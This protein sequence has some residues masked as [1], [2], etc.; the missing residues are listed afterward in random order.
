MSETSAVPWHPMAAYLYV[1]WLDGPDLAWEYLRRH[2]N[3]RRDWR[4]RREGAAPC[5]GLRLL[6]DPG[7]DA[8]DALPAWLCSRTSLQLHP[9]A[10][11]PPGVPGFR[12]WNLPGRRQLVRDD[13]CLRLVARW[14]GASL[15]AVLAP[16]LA[17]GMPGV[18]ATP[19]GV[20]PCPR[21]G[22]LALGAEPN[23]APASAARVSARPSATALLEL[24][25]L[26]ALDATLAGASLREVARG[27][28]GAAAVGGSWHADSGLRSRV[29]RLVRRGRVLMQGGYRDLLTSRGPVQRGRCRACA[30]RP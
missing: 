27:L 17:D 15:R 24:H 16:G 19:T 8:R 14:P 6:E 7:L 30:K 1:L 3:Y 13:R 18:F 2:P 22:L 20:R 21:C 25:T 4:W 11:P 9:D 29:R 5:W 26:R 28:F 23:E 12:F 10:D